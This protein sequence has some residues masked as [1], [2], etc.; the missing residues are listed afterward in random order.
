MS[1]GT[2][3]YLA[4]CGSTPEEGGRRWVLAWRG[5]EADYQD[6]IADVTVF[7]RTADY[8]HKWRVHGGFLTALQAVWGSWWNPTSR[9]CWPGAA[10]PDWRRP[11]W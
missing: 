7:K 2:N 8:H 9:C 3:A 5:T 6:I 1:R 10:S 4:R 11:A